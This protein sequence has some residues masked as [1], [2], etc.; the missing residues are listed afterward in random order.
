MTLLNA[1]EYV[2]SDPTHR[3]ALYRLRSPEDQSIRSNGMGQA[4]PGLS[5]IAASA[6]NDLALLERGQGP[7]GS[8][9]KRDIKQT[10]RSPIVGCGGARGPGLL[11]LCPLFGSRFGPA[12]ELRQDRR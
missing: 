6:T 9:S 7:K 5:K 3:I 2:T 1:V 4:D 12:L 8:G 10:R 11:S